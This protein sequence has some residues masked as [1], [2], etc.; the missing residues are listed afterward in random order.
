MDA[1][2][3]SAEIGWSNHVR[4]L[5]LSAAKLEQARVALALALKRAPPET[6][7]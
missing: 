6:K 1:L 2:L 7:P 3:V 5:A 4:R